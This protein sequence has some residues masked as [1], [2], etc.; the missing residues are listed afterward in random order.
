MGLHG[1]LG[2]DQALGDLRVRQALRDQCEDLR[3]ALGQ[4]AY[5]LLERGAG[6]VVQA[7]ELGDQPPGDAGRQQRVAGRHH[8]YRLGQLVRRRVL[9]EEPGR[10]RAQRLVHV[11]VEVE[12]G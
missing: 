2:D 9:E 6:P 3:L 5:A 8:P 7:G 12:G 1:L 4:V 11:L 10:A